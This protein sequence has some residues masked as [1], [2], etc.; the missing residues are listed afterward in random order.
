MVASAGCGNGVPMWF[1]QLA[2]PDLIGK[3]LTTDFPYSVV[4]SINVKYVDGYDVC[5]EDETKWARYAGD[6][7]YNLLNECCLAM[8]SPN[9]GG[10]GYTTI[11]QANMDFMVLEGPGRDKFSRYWR[12]MAEAVV[13]HPSAVA[14]EFMNEPMTIR[15]TAAF[16]TW[17]AA[18]EAVLSVIPD[19]SVS[20]CNTGEGAITPAIIGENDPGALLSPDTEAWIESSSN[21]YYAWHWYGNP[22]DPEDAIKNAQALGNSWNVPILLTEFGSCD[23]MV[24]AQA[25]NLSYLY[26]HY[27]SYCTTGPA[28]GNRTVPD[29]TFGACILGWAG[30]DSSK[31]C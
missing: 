22:A 26:W 24:A 1:S 16:D 31:S 15:R 13:N 20:V 27:S 10:L 6:P 5:G 11:A 12:L 7:N 19:M 9:P 23:A 18:S 14:V 28:F 2:A 17:R 8:N 29:D 30:G 4:K 3:P 21:V 25:H